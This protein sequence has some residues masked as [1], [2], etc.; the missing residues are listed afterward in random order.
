MEF[1]IAETDEQL[2]S[3]PFFHDPE[4]RLNGLH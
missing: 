4:A 1:N 2:Q 3:S